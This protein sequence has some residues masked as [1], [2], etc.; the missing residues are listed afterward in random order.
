MGSLRLASKSLSRELRNECK[1]VRAAA[2]PGWHQL[3]SGTER[4]IGSPASS[5]LQSIGADGGCCIS[6]GHGLGFGSVGG[7]STRYSG[8]SRLILER[9]VRAPYSFLS[10]ATQHGTTLCASTSARAHCGTAMLFMVAA[11]CVRQT[12]PMRMG[13]KSITSSE[14]RLR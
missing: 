10:D 12:R 11:S 9:M 8:S 4:S 13:E 2:A 1:L 5:F 14:L 7:N 3:T 6:G